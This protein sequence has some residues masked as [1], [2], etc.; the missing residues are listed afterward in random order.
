MP[1]FRDGR[2]LQAS[3][4]P[5]NESHWLV[6]AANFA[7]NRCW[8]IG[9]TTTPWAILDSL[10]NNQSLSLESNIPPSAKIDPSTIIDQAVPKTNS[11]TTD[12][13]IKACCFAAAQCL[14]GC[15]GGSFD[16]SHW[17]RTGILTNPRGIPILILENNNGNNG[18][19]KIV[20]WCANITGI[21]GET[22]GRED[23]FP[24]RMCLG[25][26]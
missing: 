23:L 10:Q 9:I 21:G 7:W 20:N 15:Q 24:F 19:S 6:T 17:L 18:T 16:F 22:P 2:W 5:E 25:K 3:S 8:W 13:Q 11:P 14:P 4:E 12:L 26:M 1:V